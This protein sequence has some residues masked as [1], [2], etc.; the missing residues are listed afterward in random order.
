MPLRRQPL[1]EVSENDAPTSI[2][3]ENRRVS[4]RAVRAP[5]KFVPDA[6]SSRSGNTGAKRK[7]GA[8]DTAEDVENEIEEDEESEEEEEEESAD[9]EEIR[10][11]KKRAKT[12]KK[13]APKKAKVNGVAPSTSAPAVRLPSRQKKPK[14]VVFQD[15]NAEGLYGKCGSRRY[16]FLSN[17]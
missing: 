12:T 2:A 13:P 3:T 7:R 4:Q 16:S 17:H 11:T 9:E 1:M 5:Q 10:Q 8:V 15:A 14:R 6:P